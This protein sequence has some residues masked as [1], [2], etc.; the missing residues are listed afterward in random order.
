MSITTNINFIDSNFTYNE[1]LRAVLACFHDLK[2]IYLYN[3]YVRVC[4]NILRV[5]AVLKLNEGRYE[6]SDGWEKDH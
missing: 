3:L 4:G 2:L 1:S 6:V 5:S